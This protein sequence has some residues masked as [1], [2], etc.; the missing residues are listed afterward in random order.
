VQTV[1]MSFLPDVKLTCESCRGQ[2]F[3]PETL[4]VRYRGRS[5]GEVLAMNIE[6]AAEFFKPHAAVHHVLALLCDVGL[7]YLTLGQ[8]SPTLSGGEAQRIKL[9]TELAKVRADLRA[10]LRARPKHTLY[11]LDEPTVGLHMADVEKLVRVLHRLVD[12]GNTVVLVEH[13]LDVIA[14][15]DW[16]VDMGPEAGAGGGKLVAAAPPQALARRPGRSHTGRALRDFL[17][18]RFE[19]AS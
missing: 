11:V 10:P 19:A 14:E 13:N 2:R 18:D 9:V 12:A 3:D 17:V 6:D 5:V 8:Q 1:E 4:A 7:G 16:V 15:A